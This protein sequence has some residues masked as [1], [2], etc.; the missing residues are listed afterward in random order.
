M[1]DDVTTALYAALAAAQADMPAVEK[2]G[3]NPHFKSKHVTLDHLIAMTRPVLN[4]HGLTIVQLPARAED[5]MPVLRTIIT[6][7]GGGSIDDE[8][9][10]LPDKVGMQAL[11]SAITYMRR[12]AWAAACGI[13][14]EEDDDG[15]GAST[16]KAAPETVLPPANPA[17]KKKLNML[18]G[19]MRDKKQITTE[20]LWQAMRPQTLFDWPQQLSWTELREQLT[21]A[22]A[23]QL[24]DRLEKAE[25]VFSAQDAAEP[26]FRIPD[27]ATE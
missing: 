2:T 16:G 18:V 23:S 25:S 22:E 27:G 21:Q 4:K 6:H 9:P 10:L 12:Y 13:A 24:I 20:Q 26:Q 14:S 5:G 17:Q 15:Q 7:V 1:S 19:T 11:G 8:A 3:R